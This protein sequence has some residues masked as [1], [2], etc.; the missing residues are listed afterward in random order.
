MK[1]NPGETLD[2]IKDIKLFQAKDGYRFS[3]DAL[4][5]EYFISAKR[6]E[7]G[8]ELGAGSGIIS[9]LLAKRLK[10]SGI[11]AVEI[12]KNLAERARRNVS[13]NDLEGR[14]EIL[15]KDMKDLKKIFAAN[16]FDFVFTNP[17][18]RKT[19]TGR[20]SAYEER[21]VARHEIVITLPELV[22]TAARLLKHSGKFFMIYHP[23]RLA[24][25]IS[26]LQK[27]RLEPKKIRFVHSKAGG[28]ARMVLLEAVKGSGAWLKVSPPLY[29]YEADSGYTP[30]LKEILGQG[31]LKRV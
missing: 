18:F 13:L 2:S 6:L 28:E 29:I 14:V 7:K 10:H 15:E 30:E 12:Q 16:S 27:S 20:L 25:L 5:L 11:I 4:L 21:A 1:P 19:E 22:K 31:R 24:E 17:P 23:F 9:I 3:I 26:L 8:I